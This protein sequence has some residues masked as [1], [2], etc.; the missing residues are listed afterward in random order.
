MLDA[1]LKAIII[2]VLLAV[3]VVIGFLIL[4]GDAGWLILVGLVLL[5]T[6]GAL[7]QWRLHSKTKKGAIRP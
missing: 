7:Y 3:M 2:L 5:A 6:G 1:M 4:L